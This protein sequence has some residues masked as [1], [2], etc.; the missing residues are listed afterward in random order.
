MLSLPMEPEGSRPCFEAPRHLN[1]PAIA[2]KMES[3]N[4]GSMG[5]GSPSTWC[6]E[7]YNQCL[8]CLVFQILDTYALRCAIRVDCICMKGR[9]F[10][11][12]GPCEF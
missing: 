1:G 10:I 8:S 4:I 12:N 2:A 3:S 5:D 9:K 7:P 6:Q 11:H